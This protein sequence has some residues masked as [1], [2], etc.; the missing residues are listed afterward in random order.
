MVKKVDELLKEIDVAFPFMA[1]P[2]SAEL[3]YHGNGCHECTEVRRYLNASRSAEV[4]D[5][6]I[7]L[8]HQDLYHLSPMALRWILPHYLKFCVSSGGLHSQEEVYFLVFNLSPDAEFQSDTY[9]RLSLLNS[10]QRKCL[11]HFLNWC[12]SN[13]NWVE[14]TEDID[15]AINFLQSIN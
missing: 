14:V 9:Q 13:E 4:D 11:I 5:E 6:L 2:E 10:A 1:M 3:T 7:G 15:K 8:L 12:T